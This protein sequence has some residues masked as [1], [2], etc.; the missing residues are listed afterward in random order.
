MIGIL[1]DHED[2]VRPKTI[3]PP[4]PILPEP[5]IA[6]AIYNEKFD[7]ASMTKYPPLIPL[8]PEKRK[9]S[10]KSV[11]DIDYRDIEE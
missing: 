2:N 4:P 5:T 1:K 7:T 3:P 10:S 9:G 11:I 6:D 8:P